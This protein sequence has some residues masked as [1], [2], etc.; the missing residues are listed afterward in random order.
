MRVELG[1]VR[2]TSFTGQGSS[3]LSEWRVGAIL[4]AIA[5]RDSKSGELSLDIGGMNYSTRIASGSGAGPVDGEVL[6]LRVLRNSPV[7]ALETLNPAEPPAADEQMTADALRRYVPRQASPTL[8]LA[9]LGWIARGD[10]DANALPKAIAQAAAKLWQA[11][12]DTATLADPKGLQSAIARSGAFLEA[13]LANGD[14]SAGMAAANNDLKALMLTLMRTLRDYGARPEAAMSD[15]TIAAQIPS[16]RGPLAALATAPATLA[17]LDTANQQMNELARQTDGALARLTTLQ[18]TNN[19]QTAPHSMLLELPVRHE[20]RAT[21]LRLRIDQERSRHQGAATANSWTVEAAMDL[22]AIGALHARVSL[23]GQR[24]GVQLRAE[25]PA[26]VDTLS[27]R[28]P[29]LESMLR[30]S[31]LEVERIVCLHGMPVGDAGNRLTRLL[32]V[33]A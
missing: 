8:M 23:T 18:V 20:D 24:I 28:S 31:G 22:G 2:S 7:L 6:Q 32:D 1:T 5:V 9:N 13:T 19:S 27:A 26:V 11:L 4:Q 33:R 15:S 21:V 30:A 10:G 25:S 3:L 17:V 29:E 14:R 16:A 12:P